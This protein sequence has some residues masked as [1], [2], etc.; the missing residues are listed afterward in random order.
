MKCLVLLTDMRDVAVSEVILR[1]IPRDVKE[2]VNVS[3]VNVEAFDTVHANFLLRLVLDSL[4]DGDVVSIVC[5]PRLNDIPRDSVGV[6]LEN[7]VNIVGPN[8]GVMS[9]ML[10][11]FKVNRVVKLPI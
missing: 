9:W 4:Q 1:S 6:E 8:N 3:I 2:Q 11:D 5:D 7:G 10:D